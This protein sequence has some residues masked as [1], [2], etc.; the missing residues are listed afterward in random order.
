MFHK[1]SVGLTSLLFVSKKRQ[2]NKLE[3]DIFGHN[4][5]IIHSALTRRNCV[6]STQNR[7]MDGKHPFD[8]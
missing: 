3:P 5:T 7:Y 4:K 6:K 2:I 8:Q 1:L